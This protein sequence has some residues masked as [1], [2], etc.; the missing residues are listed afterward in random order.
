MARGPCSADRSVLL[1]YVSP[2]QLL[3]LWKSLRNQD[4]LVS[5]T[6]LIFIL[7]KT[8]IVISTGL[9]ALKSVIV[10]THGQKMKL[11]RSFAGANFHEEFVIDRRTSYAIEGIQSFNLSYPVGT[12]AKYA[13]EGFQPQSSAKTALNYTAIVDIFSSNLDCESGSLTY[14]ISK[15]P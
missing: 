4:W 10:E 2:F 9:F 3:A 1:D 11:I 12:T 5:S 7:L 8:L 15:T 13:M 6:I 14:T